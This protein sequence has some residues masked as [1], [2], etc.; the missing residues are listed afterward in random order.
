MVPHSQAEHRAV[1]FEVIDEILLDEIVPQQV[2][3]AELV[4]FCVAHVIWPLDLLP[5]VEVLVDLSDVGQDHLCG[6]VDLH[7]PEDAL[8]LVDVEQVAPILVGLEEGHHGLNLEGV[9]LREPVVV[10]F[11][12][13]HE[14]LQAHP[15]DLLLVLGA[16]DEYKAFQVLGVQDDVVA[17]LEL[18]QLALNG[19]LIVGDAVD[20]VELEEV[21][22][23]LVD[24]AMEDV[25]VLVVDCDDAV[26]DGVV[27]LVVH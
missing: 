16:H 25:D 18:L 15:D 13:V 21:A 9:V 12:L 26:E 8:D 6:L 2:L 14:V 22:D 27:G 4:Q 1:L 19:E 5:F 23:L 10:E 3:E 24:H 17:E 7:L 11:G 20:L